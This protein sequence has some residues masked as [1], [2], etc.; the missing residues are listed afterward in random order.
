MTSLPESWTKMSQIDYREQVPAFEIFQRIR[1]SYDWRPMEITAEEFISVNDFTSHKSLYARDYDIKINRESL[2]F[3]I[4]PNS[5]KSGNGDW[6][7][8]KFTRGGSCKISNN[9]E[10]KKA[11]TE[12]S[13]R[14]SAKKIEFE[15][16][17]KQAQEEEL[18]KLNQ[19]NKKQLEKNQ[20]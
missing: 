20:I 8:T 18:K 15:I 1:Q 14:A 19:E 17:K 5:Y 4:K 3:F 7:T 13:K 2:D 6:I 11:L 9:I 16:K 12:L 10:I